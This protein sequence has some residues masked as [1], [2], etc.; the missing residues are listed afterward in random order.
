[1][2][3]L[4][5]C[6]LDNYSD[7][8]LNVMLVYGGRNLPEYL[9]QRLAVKPTQKVVNWTGLFTTFLSNLKDEWSA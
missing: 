2:V 5:L 3:S 1:M 8:E 4:M 9:S 7:S 6:G